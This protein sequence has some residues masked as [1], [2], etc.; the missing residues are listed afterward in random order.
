MNTCPALQQDPTGWRMGLSSSTPTT[1]HPISAD[2]RPQATA[3][4]RIRCFNFPQKVPGH[5]PR[6]RPRQESE[7]TGKH[8]VQ[9]GCMRVRI[10]SIRRDAANLTA[11]NEHYTP[12]RAKIRRYLRGP[13]V[14][15]MAGASRHGLDAVR[16][17]CGWD[18]GS[19]GG[20]P[21]WRALRAGDAARLRLCLASRGSTFS[22]W[23]LYP[24]S[25]ER[26]ALMISDA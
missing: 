12:D 21:P 4:G 11:P 16:N 1:G 22:G 17:T 18:C 14:T 2:A 3:L 5:Q 6:I 7:S 26:A 24:L 9:H 15:W 8:A 20:E 25:H 10:R 13:P 23:G 19:G